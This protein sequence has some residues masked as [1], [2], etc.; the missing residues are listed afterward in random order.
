MNKSWAK[1][2]KILCIRP[3]NIGDLLMT[4][5]ALRAL[6][7]SFDCTVTVL[8]SSMA[9][10]VVPFIP[11]IDK[12]I[13][14]DVPWVK[15][16]QLI[17][18]E[19]FQE[20]ISNIK[21]AGFDAAIVFTVYSQNP[22]PSI[23][24]AYLAGIPHRLSY[25]RENPYHLLTDWIPDKE[26]YTMIQH[27][28]RRDLRLV[29]SVGAFTKNQSLSVSVRESVWPAL[30]QRLVE[31]GV[32]ATVPWILFHPGVTEEKRK[33]PI[34]YWIEAGRKIIERYGVQ[35]LITGTESEN[36]LADQIQ[37]GIGSG[38]FSIA[39][40]LS[41]EEFILLIGKSPLIISVNTSSIHIA[42]ATNTAVIVLYALTNPQHTPWNATGKLLWYDVPE[43]MR[44]KNEVIKFV[45]D[46]LHPQNAPMIKPDQILRAL[47]D[48]LA[49]TDC[50]IPEMIPLRTMEEQFF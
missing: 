5:P 43:S 14:Y 47:Q 12:V 20:V 36:K 1:C 37:Q 24:L 28:V 30:R 3:D 25:C 6:K 42:A 9:A 22:M 31:L 32:N 17:S 35:I 4:T 41:L 38:S 10:G 46:N 40:K 33:Y 49:G 8:T 2:K 44:S 18:T 50:V 48:I 23:M 39:G 16:N 11:E 27:Q 45:Q 7:E 26:P 13:V 15:S 29:E 34:P 19:A 21:Q